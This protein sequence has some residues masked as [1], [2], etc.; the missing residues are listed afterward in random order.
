VSPILISD[1]APSTVKINPNILAINIISFDSAYISVIKKQTL[2]IT[3]ENVARITVYSK[4][5]GYGLIVRA[6]IHDIAVAVPNTS[7]I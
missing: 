7:P 4:G 2:S 3:H 6:I 1:I 5:F